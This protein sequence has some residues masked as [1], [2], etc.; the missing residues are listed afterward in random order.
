M[1]TIDS[2]WMFTFNKRRVVQLAVSCLRAAN[3]GLPPKPCG[4][5]R[6]RSPKPTRVELTCMAVFMRRLFGRA[7]ARILSDGSFSRRR[8]FWR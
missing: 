6:E 5:R 4:F 7:P 1:L 3:L 2:W 8:A